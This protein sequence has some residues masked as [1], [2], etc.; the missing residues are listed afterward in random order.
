MRSRVREIRTHGSVRGAFSNG[1]PYRVKWDCKYHVVWI[2]KYRKKRLFY[3]LR[4]EIGPVLRELARQKDCAIIEGHLM[5][6]H[7]H[8]LISIPPKYSVS[9]VMGYITIREV[10]CNGPSPAHVRVSGFSD[11]NASYILQST[12]RIVIR[13]QI[14]AHLHIVH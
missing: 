14:M 12:C 13:Y 6:D 11:I 3:A 7:V 8:M 1:R 5:E 4:Q 9:S 2:P 10:D